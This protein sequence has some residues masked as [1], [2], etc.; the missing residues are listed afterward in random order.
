MHF[1]RTKMSHTVRD[2]AARKECY[3]WIRP[4]WP[5]WACLLKSFREILCQATLLEVALQTQSLHREPFKNVGNCIWK[6]HYIKVKNTPGLRNDGKGE[7]PNIWAVS[8]L[9]NRQYKALKK[10]AF[11]KMCPNCLVHHSP[12]GH[13]KRTWFSGWTTAFKR[14]GNW[15]P[16]AWGTH[17]MPVHGRTTI[18]TQNVSETWIRLLAVPLTVGPCSFLILQHTKK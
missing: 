4:Q 9:D 11:E 5:W 10:S 16:R 13:K 17:S 3:L 14:G 12:W 2:I 8:A 6:L 15:N 7:F 1:A 18:R